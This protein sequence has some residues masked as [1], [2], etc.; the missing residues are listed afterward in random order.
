MESVCLGS[1]ATLSNSDIVKNPYV[2][3][4]GYYLPFYRICQ[5]MFFEYKESSNPIPYLEAVSFM[6]ERVRVIHEDGKKD[7]LWALEH[8][9]LYTAGTSAKPEDLKSPQFPVFETGRGGQYTYHGVGQR[10]YYFICNLRNRFQ[11]PDIK[12]YIWMLEESILLSLSHFKIQG[13]R[14]EG[15]IGIWVVCPDQKERK[16]AAIGVRVRHWVA[17]H[18]VSVNLNPDL[19]HFS[20]IVPCGISE[21]GVTSFEALGVCVSVEEF[22]NAFKENLEKVFSAL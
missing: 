8:P 3:M 2:V 20:G 15:R 14:R 19:S 18:G 6:E 5:Y 22:D 13:E 17:Y 12:K 4:K 7:L 16:I 1:C 9:S 10:I 21:Y 11:D